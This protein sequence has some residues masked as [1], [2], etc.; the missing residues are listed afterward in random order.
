[1]SM[2]ITHFA[3]GAA[4]TTVLVTLFFSLGPSPLSALVGNSAWDRLP[5]VPY[6]RTV[7]LF[8]GVWAMLPDAYRISPVGRSWLFDFHKGHWADLF[9]FHRTLDV[10]D[11]HDSELAA[12]LAVLLLIGATAATELWE[13]RAAE[14][15]SE[16]AEA[17]SPEGEVVEATS[18]ESARKR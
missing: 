9:W 15:V 17:A 4:M 2:A 3:F 18:E 8:G 10:L 13:L 7:V 14:R 12:I 5:A 16:T 6:P 1:M 11:P